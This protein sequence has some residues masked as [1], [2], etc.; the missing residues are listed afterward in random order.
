MISKIR[1]YLSSCAV[2]RRDN[3]GCEA[4]RFICVAGVPSVIASQYRVAVE[5][6]NNHTP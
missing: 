2:T 5:L 4:I 3:V 1:M 6:Y